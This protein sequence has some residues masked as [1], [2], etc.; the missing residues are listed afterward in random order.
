MPDQRLSDRI[1]DYLATAQG[2]VVYLTDIRQYLKIEPGS[3][4]DANLRTQMATTMVKRKVVSPSGRKDGGYKVITQVSPVKVFSVDRQRRDPFDLWFP[5]DWSTGMELSFAEHI[6]IREGDLITIGGTKSSG[7]TNL[8]LSFLAEN[9]DRTPVLMGN[10]YTVLVEDV[11]EPAPRFLARLDRMAEWVQWVNGTG[12][13]KFSLLPVRDDYAEHIIS[14]RLNI[15]D[16]INLDAGVLYDIG[17]VL[18]GLKKNNGRGVT[19]AA[20][21]KGEGATNPRGGQFVRDFSDV[22]I[23]LDIFGKNPSDVLLTIKGVKEANKPIVGKTFAYT[24]GEAGTKLFNFREVVKC[25]GCNG[26]GKYK[27]YE[28]DRCFGSGWLDY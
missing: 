14:G 18:E 10:E 16:W 4:D 20:L 27:G 2:R 15:I 5:R 6:V 17:K 12:L 25:N 11:Y 23:L 7:K 22:E 24:I 21:Q 9:I 26:S 19:I 13:D 8:C 28:C 3:S 1:I